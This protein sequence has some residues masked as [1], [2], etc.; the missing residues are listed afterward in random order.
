MTNTVLCVLNNLLQRQ[1]MW[2]LDLFTPIIS[3]N[4]N[5]AVQLKKTSTTIIF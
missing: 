1:I 5:I 4:P 3:K 2:E